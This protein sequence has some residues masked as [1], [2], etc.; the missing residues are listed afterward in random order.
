M[1]TAATA[2]PLIVTPAVGPV[3]DRDGTRGRATRI[4]L[5]LALVALVLVTYW[6]TVDNGFL[7]FGFDDAIILDTPELRA[8]TW[9]NAWTILTSFNHA[10]YVPL[11]MLS[12]AADYSVWGL[13]PYGY[14]LTN[15]LVHAMA[16]V[17]AYFWLLGL[18]P[19]WYAAL[20][21]AI[22]AVHPLQM[23]A[24]SVAIQ[25]KTLLSG[26]L[27]FATLIW[28][29]QWCRRGAPWL[30][31]A[32]LIT[33]VA[34]ALAKPVVAS[35][36]CI[37]LLY[38]HTFVDAQRRRLA[39]VLPFFVI[40]GATCLAAAAAHTQV[41][42][43]H[44]PHGG[45]LLVHAL[46]VSRALLESVTALV[47]PA[48]LSPLYYYP[49]SFGYAPLNFVALAFIP[50]LLVWV[51]LQRGRHPWPFFCVWWIAL[52][53]APEANIF[54]LA[55]L[56]ADR[57]MYLAVLAAGIAFAVALRWLGASLRAASAARAVN[58]S[59]PAIAVIVLALLAGLS[60]R[61]AIVWRNDLTAWMRVVDRHSW[62]V[63]AHTMLGRAY[64]AHGFA[65]A[66]ERQFLASTHINAAV[67]DP[68]LYLAQLYMDR[69]D[70]ARAETTLD[71]VLQIVPDHPEAR[72]LRDRVRSG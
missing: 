57:F 32:A 5:G 24:V 66:A 46:M 15:V 34:A 28:Y 64:L 51:T 54:P 25:R 17:L 12:L 40:A 13:D 11:T 53:C 59:V 31:A 71:Q 22:F 70:R 2:L 35:L 47:L 58:V 14:H 20:A 44:G 55:Q 29:Q 50:L 33:Y 68:Y 21:A 26:A 9:Q 7:P 30:Y 10:H 16:A 18:L 67:A 69:G 49:K 52:V 65:Q 23:E 19:T 39:H 6:P 36:P 1:A 63:T 4:G 41:G 27:F 45:T 48:N 56:R 3:G 37:L 43:T 61:S 38:E 62:S 72:R 8:L 42:G 60:Y